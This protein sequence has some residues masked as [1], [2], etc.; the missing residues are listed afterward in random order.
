MDV[1]KAVALV[2]IVVGLILAPFAIVGAVDVPFLTERPLHQ[3]LDA[4]GIPFRTPASD[5]TQKYGAH[6]SAWSTGLSVCEITDARPL[7]GGLAQPISFTWT[8]RRSSSL[9]AWPASFSAYVRRSTDPHTNF[10][11]VAPRLTELFGDGD[12]TSASNTRS[13]RWRFGEATVT[14][15]V[16]PPELQH[17]REYPSY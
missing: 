10:E 12:D 2:M 14:A 11:W 5:L 8:E 6:E 13:V 16:F 7:I 9:A 1:R 3:V 4:C 17:A 15:R